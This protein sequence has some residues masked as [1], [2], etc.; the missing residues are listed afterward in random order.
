MSLFY[1]K[2]MKFYLENK[3]IIQAVRNVSRLISDFINKL[4]NLAEWYLK[5]ISQK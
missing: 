5:R 4:C 1:E 2:H 3:V